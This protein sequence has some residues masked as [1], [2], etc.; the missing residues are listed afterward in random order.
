[1]NRF[2]VVLPTLACL[3]FSAASGAEA[4]KPKRDTY[5]ITAEEIA[6]SGATSAYEAIEKLR[7]QF[8]R[9]PLNSQLAGLSRSGSETPGIVVYHGDRNLGDLDV[10][11][12]VKA[13]EVLEIRYYRPTEASGK[14][15]IMNGSAAIVLTLNR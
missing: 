1:M 2:Y 12:H 10:L 14:L 15:G 11:K 13:E 8:L 3:T 6:Q 7:P 5:V 4:Q 9:P